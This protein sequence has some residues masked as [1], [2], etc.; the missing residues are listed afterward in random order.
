M[1]VIPKIRLNGRIVLTVALCLL[2]SIAC[3]SQDLNPEFTGRPYYLKENSLANFERADGVLSATAG[4]KGMVTFYGVTGV[5]SEVRF[6]KSSLPSILI[7]VD[8]GVD[9]VEIFSVV[10]ANVTKKGREF[11]VR[12]TDKRNAPQDLSEFLVKVNFT[13]KSE[14]LYEL[15]FDGGITIGEYAIISSIET[16]NSTSLKSK[17][18]CFGIE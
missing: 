14:G 11:T 10:R 7:K 8:A 4:M 17:I 1:R 3:L 9:P 13:K 6:L 18:S 5:K 12:K 2:G 15:K 16:A